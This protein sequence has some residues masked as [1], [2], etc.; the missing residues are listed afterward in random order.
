MTNEVIDLEALEEQMNT[1]NK[2]IEELKKSHIETSK[3]VFHGAVSAFF[4]MYPEIGSITWTQYTPYFNDGDTCEF[5]VHDV[6]FL[7]TKDTED[8]DLDLRDLYEHNP[9]EKPD[10]YVYRNSKVENSMQSYYLE[11]IKKWDD[12][13]AKLGLERIQQLEAGIKK[14]RKTFNSISDDTMLSLFGDHVR[15]TAKPTGIDVDEYDHE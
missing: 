8:E 3:K 9:W 6:N 14:F 7:S 4:K 5:S 2:Q 10:D 11:K 1:V 12:E 15:V 13:V